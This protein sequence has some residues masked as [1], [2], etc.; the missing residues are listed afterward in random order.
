MCTPAV[1]CCCRNEHDDA[2]LIFSLDVS[3]THMETDLVMGSLLYSDH[4]SLVNT[5][6]YQDTQVISG[7]PKWY[8]FKDG[9]NMDA[10]FREIASFTQMNETHV[11][12][13]D[14][15]NHCIRLV[16]RVT[17]KT[18]TFAG[19][20]RRSGMSDGL[21]LD[22]VRFNH[23]SAVVMDS[24]TDSIYVMDSG[25]SRI[26]LINSGV[27]ISINAPEKDMRVLAM[28]S[29]TIYT[30]GENGAV[31]AIHPQTLEFT[32]LFEFPE[33][34]KKTVQAMTMLDSQTVVAASGEDAFIF[35][36]SS[37]RVTP[38]C[39]DYC[40]QPTAFLHGINHFYIAAQG[41]IFVVEFMPDDEIL[42]NLPEAVMD[43]N[44]RSKS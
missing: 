10:K 8:G 9:D 30:M 3:V 22:D 18:S 23:P 31:Y 33:W 34:K 16:S 38:L 20:C 37:A 26:V 2:R 43:G 28:H 4:Y 42:A 40:K 24:R 15:L 13:A 12:V 35:S 29:G 36:N 17:G 5:D 44:N 39:E 7:T 27:A 25:N 32:T 41:G 21:M 19:S 1:L 14:E 6:F 11:L